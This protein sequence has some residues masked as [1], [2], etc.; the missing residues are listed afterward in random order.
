MKSLQYQSICALALLP[1]IADSALAQNTRAR[2]TTSASKEPVSYRHIEIFQG[3]DELKRLMKQRFNT[4]VDELNLRLATF[5]GS[6]GGL[7]TVQEVASRVAQAGIELCEKPEEKTAIYSKNLQLMV[8]LE[9]MVDAKFLAGE[10]NAADIANAK[11]YRL[12]A[13]IQ[14]LKFKRK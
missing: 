12:D 13:E 5:E 2:P 11:Y 10:G 1:F 7:K 4:A 9:A 3:D 8:M 6:N 14:L